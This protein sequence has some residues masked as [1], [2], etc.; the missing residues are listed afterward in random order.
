MYNI[1]IYIYLLL[2][3]V[4]TYILPTFLCHKSICLSS[5][6]PWVAGLVGTFVSLA[7]GGTHAANALRAAFLAL[8]PDFQQLCPMDVDE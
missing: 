8:A 6:Y 4:Y 1:Y 7:L 2:N 3:H 5:S